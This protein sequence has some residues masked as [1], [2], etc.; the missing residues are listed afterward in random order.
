V[1]G[2][3]QVIAPAVVGCAVSCG[4]VLFV[5]GASKLYRCGRGLDEMSAIRRALRIPQR[6]WR[7]FLLA[8][9][10]AECVTGAVVCSGAYPVVGG[11]TLAALGAVF[12]AL[13]VIVRVK[14]FPGGCGCIRWRRPSTTSAEA[15]TWRPIARSGVLLG[16]GLAYMLV[17]A[18]AVGVPRQ[19]W[20]GAGGAAGAVILM[21][22]S[23][24]G[25][26]RA[27]GCRRLPWLKTRTVL[28]ELA[29]H[30]AFGAM[31]SSAGPFGPIAWHRR[32][33]CTDEFWLTALAGQDVHAVIFQVHRA[34][35]GAQLAVHA[36]L[37]SH[38]R[39]GDSWPSRAIVVADVLAGTP[40]EA[41]AGDYLHARKRPAWGLENTRQPHQHPVPVLNAAGAPAQA[42]KPSDKRWE[43][44]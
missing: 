7:L 2:I 5:A 43:M 6:P 23:M 28:R 8:A 16:T 22:L 44:L 12:C 42:G 29:G 38:L 17:S 25:P 32:S 41:Q 27:D 26:V 13:L 3:N 39:P 33:G 15:I 20:F 9:G 4:A 1:I 11:A 14:H 34:A 40:H 18:D 21:L 30:E 37:R 35:P 36:S 31:A 10:V 19:Y 24:P